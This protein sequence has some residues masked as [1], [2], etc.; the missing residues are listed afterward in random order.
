MRSFVNLFLKAKRGCLCTQCIKQ[1][2]HKLNIS[3][4]LDNGMKGSEAKSASKSILSSAFRLRL[5]ASGQPLYSLICFSSRSFCITATICRVVHGRSLEHDH[6][7]Q[8]YGIYTDFSREETLLWQQ[9]VQGV[10]LEMQMRARKRGFSEDQ[11]R[12]WLRLILQGL[13][14]LHD[15][16][17]VVGKLRASKV[18]I[19]RDGIP[20]IIDWALPPTMYKSIHRFVLMPPT[21]QVHAER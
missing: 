10:S 6:L 18:V 2:E 16:G 12:V 1:N 14:H 21:S 5:S 11:V 8:Y 4:N 9:H 7:A 15:N 13:K 20:V 3:T 19:D 17:I